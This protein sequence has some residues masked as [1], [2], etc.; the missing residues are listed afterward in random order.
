MRLETANPWQQ[1]VSPSLANNST[2]LSTLEIDTRQH[3]MHNTQTHL[4]CPVHPFAMLKTDAT[5]G[6]GVCGVRDETRRRHAETSRLSTLNDI[7]TTPPFTPTMT[8]SSSHVLNPT[9]SFSSSI[10]HCLFTDN[11]QRRLD[12]P[13]SRL[14]GLHKQAQALRRYGSLPVE[15]AGWRRFQ[16]ERRLS[17]SE[18]RVLGSGKCG[19][20]TM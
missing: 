7:L 14:H 17:R 1:S 15:L 11:H 19:R 9:R 16:V 18:R 13:S 6:S 8:N 5:T 10:F 2:R 20:H 4:H 12:P 3:T